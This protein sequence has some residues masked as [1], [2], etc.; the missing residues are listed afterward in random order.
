LAEIAPDI[1]HPLLQKPI[2]A[3]F[4]ELDSSGDN[5]RENVRRLRPLVLDSQ[6]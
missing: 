5:A 6:L 2:G 3:I 1:V 4:R